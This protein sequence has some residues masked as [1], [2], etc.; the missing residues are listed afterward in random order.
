VAESR[1]RKDVVRARLRRLVPVLVVL[2]VWELLSRSGWV[3][4]R[5]MPSVVLIAQALWADLESGLLAFHAMAS[6]SRA[7]SGFALAVLVGVPLGVLMARV[8]WF[9]AM[10]E[11]IF[12]FGYPVP[13]IALYPLFV[14]ALGFG[15]PSKVALIFLECLFP[16]VLNTC[17]GV[18]A[19]QR[20]YLWSAANMGASPARIFFRVLLPA[21]APVV[22]SG[23]RVALPLAMVVVVITE[24]IGDSRG[25]GYFISYSS[26]SFK[27][28]S[29]YAGVAMVALMGFVL[30]RALVALRSR[31]IF[32]ER[33]PALAH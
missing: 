26:A 32:W 8:R 6:L 30:D 16:I 5:L 22:F 17:F 27:Y 25:L 11:P 1:E 14:F 13:K 7:L 10:V 29:A 28:P 9:D 23:I 21:A 24:M 20:K 12:S 18:R 31:I 2:L 33:V 15:S 3:S 4:A 19:V